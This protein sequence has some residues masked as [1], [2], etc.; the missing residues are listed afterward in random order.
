MEVPQRLKASRRGHRVHIRKLLGKID[1]ILTKEEE[2]VQQKE[3]VSLES[4]LHQLRSKFTTL[5]SLD[6]RISESIDK[7]ADLEQEVIESEEL[8]SSIEEKIHITSKFLESSIL[9]PPHAAPITSP[10]PAPAAPE[11]EL[12][13]PQIP[14]QNSPPVVTP[15]SN[16]SQ[17]HNACKLPKLELPTFSGNSLHWQGFWDSFESAIH[18][19]PNLSGVQKFNYLKAQVLGDAAQVI[20]GFPLTNANY[21]QSLNLLKERFG[22][23]SKIVNAHMNALVQ[24]PS[25]SLDLPSLRSF[26]DNVEK[27]IRGL[28]S[29]GVSHDSYGSLLVSILLG[30]LP[31]DLR[32]TL[33]REHNTSDW[34]LDQVRK[35]I[36]REINILE[37]GV[38]FNLTGMSSHA[39]PSPPLP[40]ASFFTTAQKRAC[41]FCKATH[42]SSACTLEHK[43]KITVIKRD[44][45]C[46][47]CLGKHKI[48]ECKSKSRCKTCGR[49]HHTSICNGDAAAPPSGSTHATSSPPPTSL[50]PVSPPFTPSSQTKAQ[51]GTV[52]TTLTPVT[53]CHA[54]EI[55]TS[56]QH[57][58]SLLKT[59]VAVVTSGHK[60]A[61]ANILFDEG[62]QRSFITAQ[63]AQELQLQTTRTEDVTLSS[64]GKKNPTHQRLE[65]ARMFI[66]T[67]HGQRI[68]LNVL[69]VPKI[70][71]PLQNR[72]REHISKVPH[73]RGLKLAHPVTSNESFEISLLI[74][75]DHY[76]D[77]VEDRIIRGNGPTA[78]QSKLGFLLSGPLRSPAASSQ[79][80]GVHFLTTH[81]TE[82]SLLE[83]FWSVES[84]GIEPPQQ[85]NP[86]AEFLKTYQSS[87]QRMPSGGYTAKLPWKDEHPP[88][89]S[90]QAI[91]AGRTRLMLR[92]LNKTPQ[93]IQQYDSVIQDQKERGFIEK[94]HHTSPPSKHAHYLPHHPVW[95]PSSTTPLRI[96]YDCSCRQTSEHPSLND[97]L[98]IGPPLQ[99]DLCSILLR[100]RTPAIGIST[101]IEKAFLHVGLHEADRDFTRFLW[102]SDP[103]NPE[104][105]FETFRFKVIPF[106]LSS[107]PF[108]LNATLLHHLNLYDTAVAK[109]VRDNLYVDNVVTGCDT[110]IDALQYYYKARHTM[111]SANFNLR[112]WASNS[113]K[114]N[115]Q[116]TT[117][118]S[119]DPNHVVKL[120][121]MT[122]NTEADTLALVSKQLPTGNI[123][124]RQAVSGASQIYDP[125]GIIA[126]SS[127][128]PRF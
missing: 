8:R 66:V 77:I 50:S 32:K 124:K 10:D 9:S 26:F 95:K 85:T 43:H 71:T 122:W 46:F 110:E 109:D 58:V 105:P 87:I 1:E 125:L 19:N 40:T 81:Q 73:L 54:S 13:P 5:S 126:P 12:V 51:G 61:E 36:L 55:D 33:A 120:L 74:G 18:N 99:N 104:S 23:P 123:S 20:E 121:G 76:W 86:H 68:P 39:H 65:M 14:P 83:R 16:Q 67:D 106:G 101:D 47:N 78:M 118:G 127:S 30:K 117:D 88:L 3:L 119:A 48:S 70:A 31:E 35:S 2:E 29:V 82:D 45:L 100:F 37:A 25:P 42:L 4:L 103:T 116:A 64:F 41:A 97:C 79:S 90:N 60:N 89:P 17:N 28:A 102:L 108:I 113:P 92:R 38:E 7:E 93:L 75:A 80:V 107:S 56:S 34:T 59:A 94:V 128:A 44:Q 49:K 114:L 62:A 11:N 115:A 6:E 111:K 72:Y 21:E 57:S 22:N 69:V 96:V 24:L 63:L 15:T 84:M 98:E 91:S 53:S 112:S 52:L 27:N